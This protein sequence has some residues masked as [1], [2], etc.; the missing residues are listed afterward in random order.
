MR[1]DLINQL[2]STLLCQPSYFAWMSSS[3]IFF[4]MKRNRRVN[5]V[6][7]LLCK[8]LEAVVFC[9]T[10]FLKIC[11]ISNCCKLNED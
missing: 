7:K 8:Y 3:L 10:A 1:I 4:S 2:S 11:R 9:M 5:Y 6:D